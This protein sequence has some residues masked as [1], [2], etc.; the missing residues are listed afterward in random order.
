[1]EQDLSHS[2]PQECKASDEDY[3]ATLST[4]TI[5]SLPLLSVTT[6]RGITSR[7]CHVERER[8]ASEDEVVEES[9]LTLMSATA[10]TSF[11]IVMA[12]AGRGAA[13]FEGLG[14]S[15]CPSVAVPGAEQQVDERTEDVAV[16]R[17]VVDAQVV[18]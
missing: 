4:P 5:Q 14:R 1:M 10:A 9:P 15:S 11:F 13:P 3:G 16:V 18:Q 12:A 7:Q 2:L 8:R 17:P 6:G